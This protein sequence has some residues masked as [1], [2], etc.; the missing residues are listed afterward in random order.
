MKIAALIVEYNPFHNGHLR[1]IKSVRK[2]VGASGAIIALMSG[3]FTQRGEISCLDKFTKAKLAVNLGVDLVL[4]LP[5]Q[6]VLSSADYFAET[7][8]SLIQATRF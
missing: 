5:V 3:N 6:G 2:L 7:A 8:I 4:E 1:Q